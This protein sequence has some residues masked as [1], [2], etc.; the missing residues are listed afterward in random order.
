V[1]TVAA[2]ADWS[3][4]NID[5]GSLGASGRLQHR[6]NSRRSAGAAEKHAKIT[7]L[8][9]MILEQDELPSKASVATQTS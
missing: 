4:D 1:R 7:S 5:S 2:G 6:A 3:N 8:R 9:A